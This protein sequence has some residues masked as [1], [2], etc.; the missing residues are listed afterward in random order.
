M[1]SS[2]G[3]SEEKIKLKRG[4]CRDDGMIL[5]ASAKGY[6]TWVSPDEFLD[7]KEKARIAMIEW[8]KINPLK[9]RQWAKKWRENNPEK[10][11]E[12]CA[13]W[14]RKNPEKIKVK[15]ALWTSRNPDKVKEL[16][17]KKYLKQKLRNPDALRDKSRLSASKWRANNPELSK[18]RA[19]KWQIENA[20]KTV[21]Y[22][23]K[24]E[25]QKRASIPADCRDRIVSGLYVIAERISRCTGIQHEVDHVWPLSKGGSHCHRNLQVIPAALNRRKSA[26]LDFDLPSCYQS[27]G[28]RVQKPSASP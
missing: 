20:A 15:Q 2:N 23:Q 4:N 28:R 7:K 25:A 27:E 24:R 17:R 10:A 5:W 19:R 18:Q 13:K 6:E 16:A 26:R 12:S 9:A 8:R 22:T 21:A 11:K 1:E 14:A 3:M